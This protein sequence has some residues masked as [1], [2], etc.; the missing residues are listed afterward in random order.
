MKNYLIS[1][2]TIITFL[3]FTSCKKEEFGS[4]NQILTNKSCWNKTKIETIINVQTGEY[5]DVTYLYYAPCASDDCFFYNEDGTYAYS[6][7]N[8]ICNADS[9]GFEDSGTW[10]LSP[11]EKFIYLQSDFLRTYEIITLTAEKLV[12]KVGPPLSLRFTFE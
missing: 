3:H 6:E 2:L 1:V 7:S 11:D 4:R 12:V 10:S 9:S 5:A 8:T